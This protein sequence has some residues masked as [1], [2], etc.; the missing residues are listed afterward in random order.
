MPIDR[1]VVN[2]SP[3]IT[4]AKA[5]YADLFPELF[6]VVFLPRSVARE[7][8]AGDDAASQLVLDAPWITNVAV[9]VPADISSWN[10]GDG[11]SEV[12]SLAL[13][14][15][16]LRAAVDDRA[17]RRCAEAFSIRTLGTVGIVVL[18]TRR[19]LID[20]ARIA[21]DRL[22]ASGLY[23]SDELIDSVLRKEDPR[24]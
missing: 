1:I 7:I 20:S 10:L 9:D 24:T 17:A 19:G 5:G 13:Q 12:L 23:L 11:E 4:L 16:G 3:I 6:N 14:D 18:A 22:K 2:A 21:I 15:R 8:R